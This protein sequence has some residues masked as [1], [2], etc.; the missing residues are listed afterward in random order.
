MHFPELHRHLGGATHP[1]ILWG[2]IEKQSSDLAVRLMA[3]YGDYSRFRHEFE[4]PFRDLADYLSVHHLVEELQAEDVGYFAHRAVR[5]ASVFEAVDV[6]E[7]RFNPYKRTRAGLSEDDRLADMSRVVDDITKAVQTDFPI[8]TAFI[9]CMD[10]GFS[11]ARNKAIID[12]AKVHPACVAVDIAGPYQAGG[13]TISEW[14][15]LFRYAREAGLSTTAHMAESDPTDVHPELFPYLNRI[16]HG[17]QIGLH[18]EHH[19]AELAE[20]GITLEVCPMTYLRTNTI[21]DVSELKPVFDRCRAAGVRI[22]IC[23]DNPALHGESGRLVN[24]YE[25]LVRAGV[26][27]FNDILELAD[28]GYAAAFTHPA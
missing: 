14:V 10:R 25:R 20:R 7:L 28:A 27:H 21:S 11:P 24:E 19:L 2:Y 15:E 6:L 12:L 22:A 23:T 18:H 8:R 3:R 13:P 17:I 16:G 26:I 1:R 4:R 5:G 9:L